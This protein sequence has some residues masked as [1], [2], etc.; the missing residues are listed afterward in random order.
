[1][2]VTKIKMKPGCYNSSKLVEIDELYIVECETPGYYK[3]SAVHDFVKSNP[4]HLKVNKPPYP[5]PV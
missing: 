4:G 1:M 5:K 2:Y 3:K